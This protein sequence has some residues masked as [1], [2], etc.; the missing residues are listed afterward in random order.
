MAIDSQSNALNCYAADTAGNIW[1]PF[2][3]G[4]ICFRNLAQQYDLRPGISIN[5]VLLF[6]HPVPESR[7][8]F[9]AGENHIGFRFDGINFT[10]PERVNYRYKFVGLDSSW[11]TTTDESVTFPQLPAGKYC[12]RVQASLSSNFDGAREDY[13]DFTIAKPLWKQWWALALAGLLLLAAAYA[14]LRL[15]ERELRRKAALQRERMMAEYEQLK[16]Q[17]NPHFLFNTLNT[18]ASLID[19]DSG[20]AVQYTI[21]LSDLYRSMLAYRDR[22]LIFLSEEVALLQKYVFIQQSRF[23]EGLQLHLD[24]PEDIAATKQIVPLALQLLVENAIK[25]NIVSAGQPLHIYVSASSEAITVRNTLRPKM[26]K[27]AGAGLGL[28]NISRRY[29]LLGNRPMRYGIQENNFIVTL[30]LL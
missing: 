10:N 11:V 26:S 17:V 20:A 18:L 14:G 2:E 30:P 13:F 24:I 9:E 5:E 7:T 6:M 19:E 21:Q 12:F 28:L 16:S 23:R 27:E 29:A 8:S 4:L 15:Q 22:D 25:H 3:R 1:M